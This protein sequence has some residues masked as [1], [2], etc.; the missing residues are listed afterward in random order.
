MED[1]RVG[2]VG[3]VGEVS[4]K[5][6]WLCGQEED[7]ME[8]WIVFSPGLDFDWVNFILCIDRAQV[9]LQCNVWIGCLDFFGDF[10]RI[11]LTS[12]VT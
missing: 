9:L 8:C 11:G 5:A 4:T 6:C 2:E 10:Q 7:D 3:E 1:R 12:R